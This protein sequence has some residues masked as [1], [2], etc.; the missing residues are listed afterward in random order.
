MN[1]RRIFFVFGLFVVFSCGGSSQLSLAKK[2]MSAGNHSA[3]IPILRAAMLSDSTNSEA[4]MLLGKSYA[5]IG[6]ADSAI[7][8]LERA[9]A[10]DS[11]LRDAKL[12]L[13]DVYVEKAEGMEG[14]ENL[15]SALELLERA[16]KM[17]PESFD[18][19]LTRGKKYQATGYQAKAKAEFERAAEIRPEDAAVKDAL[20]KI[21]ASSDG[22]DASFVKGQGHYNKR[23]WDAAIKSFEQAVASNADHK[24]AQYFLH[25]AR[26]RRFY[27][28]GGV[29]DLWDSISEFGYATNIRAESGEPYFYMAEA[30]V[31]KNKDDHALHIETFEK[32]IEL[33][34]E[35]ALAKK[36]QARI[37]E[38]KTRK[39]K[40]EKFWGKKKK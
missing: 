11:E 35:S 15:R 1:L 23:K 2:E 27:Q 29:D 12:A 7:W 36:A 21:A 18:V 9:V 25:M 30:Y 17:T 33:E 39:E 31:K 22:A 32:V 38:L 24:D 16:E 14:R 10:V 19:F 3:A 6:Q 20:S 13:S 28:K 37:K 40:L 34:P 5:K 8:A 26:G 4:A